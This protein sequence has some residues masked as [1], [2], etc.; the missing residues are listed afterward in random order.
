MNWLRAE[1]KDLQL[2]V[3][4]KG[5]PY[6]TQNRTWWNFNN[7]SFLCFFLGRCP[8]LQYLSSKKQPSWTSP[9][10]NMGE[11]TRYLTISKR[12]SGAMVRTGISP[13]FWLS[14]ALPLV[15]PSSHLVLQQ[16]TSSLFVFAN[17]WNSTFESL[18][19][20]MQTCIN[21][22]TLAG[23]MFFWKKSGCFVSWRKCLYQLHQ[24]NHLT[25][26]LR[27]WIIFGRVRCFWRYMI[28][29][30]MTQWCICIYI[31]S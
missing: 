26:G 20:P 28:C 22:E 5:S 19:K 17:F 27:V 1:F 4:S 16:K 18:T 31:Y 9:I 24:W 2:A 8:I 11:T 3:K 13:A 29:F 12:L 6:T 7:F 15:V 14:V 10:F 25:Q 30:W 21:L 23:S